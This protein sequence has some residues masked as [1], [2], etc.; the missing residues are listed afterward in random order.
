MTTVDEIEV[1][2]QESKAGSYD[3]QF[4]YDEDKNSVG[5]DTSVIAD[6]RA[7]QCAMQ[8]TS[9]DRRNILSRP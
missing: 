8:V 7:H 9:I 3:E 5:K 2:Y 1:Q 6:R 4:S